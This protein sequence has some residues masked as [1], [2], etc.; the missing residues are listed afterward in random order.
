MNCENLFIVPVWLVW[1]AGIWGVLSIVNSF[2]E[3]YLKIQKRKLA[4]LQGEP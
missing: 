2:L 4:K 1:C 3:L